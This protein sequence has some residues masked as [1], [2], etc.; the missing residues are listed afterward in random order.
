MLYTTYLQ[1]KSNHKKSHSYLIDSKYCIP[2]AYW[3]NTLT[4]SFCQSA[5]MYM[6][7]M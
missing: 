4:Y 1:E 2:L 6:F 7:V 5:D 3:R